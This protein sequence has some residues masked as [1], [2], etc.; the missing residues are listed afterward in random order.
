MAGIREI[1][2]SVGHF[3]M[4]QWFFLPS[5][6]FHSVGQGG[7]FDS[8]FIESYWMEQV[9]SYYAGWGDSVIVRSLTKGGIECDKSLQSGGTLSK[10]LGFGFKDK[11]E[12][13]NWKLH[14]EAGFTWSYTIQ[15]PLNFSSRTWFA[16][17]APWEKKHKK[18]YT[19]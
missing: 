1:L 13:K 18:E 10:S 16:V 9:S 7:G 3:S 2:N 4:P 15:S 11:E 14:V 17:Y 5:L 6:L 12:E 19:F 8:D